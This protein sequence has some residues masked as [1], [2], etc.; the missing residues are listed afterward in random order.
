MYYDILVLEIGTS[1]LAFMLTACCEHSA[2]WGVMWAMHYLTKE[3]KLSG[4]NHGYDTWNI[5]EH[6]SN[7]VISDVVFLNLHYGN[8][9]YLSNAAVEEDFKS[10]KE[11]LSKQPNSHPQRRMF[12][13]IA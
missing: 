13:E 7:L 10:S 3:A 4:C 5:I 1:H 8:V 12:T 2:A 9:K 6:S 11:I